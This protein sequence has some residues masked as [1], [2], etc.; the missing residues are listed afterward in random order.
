MTEQYRMSHGNIS[1]LTWCE[2]YKVDE[3]LLHYVSVGLM[4]C[5]GIR[6]WFLG[7]LQLLALKEMTKLKINLNNDF[8]ETLYY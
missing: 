1:H 3:Y 4:K 6:R 8:D 2:L 5:S 7:I